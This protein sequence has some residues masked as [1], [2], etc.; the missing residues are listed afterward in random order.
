MG[1]D[2]KNTVDWVAAKHPELHFSWF[3]RLKVQDH[4]AGRSVSGGG[5]L[6]GSWM[7]FDVSSC[8]GRSKGGFKASFLRALISLNEGSALVP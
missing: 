2:D 8:G 1:C 7:L 6:P 5:P 3:W 4:G